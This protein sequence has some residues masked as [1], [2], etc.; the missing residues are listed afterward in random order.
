MATNDGRVSA[1][2]E[3]VNTLKDSQIDPERIKKI[4][5]I[6]DEREKSNNLIIFNLTTRVD[7]AYS[8][9]MEAK[10]LALQS[11]SLIDKIPDKV[12]ERINKER[13]EKRFE[14]RDW[15]FL[16]IAIVSAAGTIGA[17]IR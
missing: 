9:G 2:V 7:E 15:M 13:K 3:A 16:F 4:E 14:S 17:L 5:T 11:N 6:L 8:I 10:E 1:L 12:I